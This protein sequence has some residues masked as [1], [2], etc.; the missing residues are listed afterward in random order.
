MILSKYDH[1]CKLQIYHNDILIYSQFF[2][3]KH[4]NIKALIEFLDYFINNKSKIDNYVFISN[5]N[6]QNS[7]NLIITEN[8]FIHG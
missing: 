3:L 6:S 7:L 4:T 1:Q 2:S 5:I 8:F